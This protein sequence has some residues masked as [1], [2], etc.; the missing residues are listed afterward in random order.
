MTLDFE[1]KKVDCSEI[2]REIN[3]LSHI[4]EDAEENLEQ[5]L[6]KNLGA[7]HCARQMRNIKSK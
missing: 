1:G 5:K 6:A 2:M 7:S 3:P 4:Y